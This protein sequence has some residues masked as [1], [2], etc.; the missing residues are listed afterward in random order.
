MKN[1]MIWPNLLPVAALIC[2]GVLVGCAEDVKVSTASKSA[3]SPAPMRFEL[4]SGAPASF[5]ASEPVAT[6][7][8]APSNNDTLVTQQPVSTFSADVDTSSYSF[9]RRLIQQG[10]L[11]PSAIIRPEEMV[12]YFTYDYQ[13]PKSPKEPFQPQVTIVPSPWTSGAQL[14]HIGIKG[15]VPPKANNRAP[16]NLV[17]LI[18]TSGSMTP[19]DRLPMLQKAFR[20][21]VKHLTDQDK[22]AIVTYASGSD[23]AL[24][25][26]SDKEDILEAI[27]D[28]S[29][30]GF[31]A[32]S[33]GLKTAYQLAEEN[34]DKG[35][36]NRV[37]LATD[38]DFNFGISDPNEL[39]QLIAKKRQSGIYLSV[40]GVGQDNYND[41]VMQALAQ[42]GN[43]I[44][45]YLDNLDEARRVLIEQSSSTFQPIANDVK[46]QV[47]FNPARVQSYRLVGYE[48]RMLAEKDFANDKVDAGDIGA[49]HS[50]T[51][52]YEVVE[53]GV[54][55]GV[56]GKR[57][58][59]ANRGQTAQ[60]AAVGDFGFLQ[61]RAKVP[62]AKTSQLFTRH[63][64]AEDQLDRLEQAKPDVRFAI[65]VAGF[66][67]KL[68]GRPI[69]DDI[70]FADIADQAEAARGT[71]KDGRRAEFIR[72][73]RLA[74]DLEE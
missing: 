44:A 5:Y 18:D 4:H 68:G 74:S 49:G 43:G 10:Q 32:G 60:A 73:A 42:K 30:G 17:F 39:E 2:T 14:I 47:E 6:F 46:F 51:A 36:N 56:V 24:K 35:A 19:E 65:A 22:V 59:A 3:A 34:F 40:L 50:V 53:V 54:T 69:G 1:Q 12:N 15:Y 48:T 25:P 27:D 70:T 71:D 11:P 7:P 31:T 16:L 41:A 45:A 64:T 13:P 29:A 66:A 52:I 61:I 26:T 8:I 20:S 33:E 28:L 23:V 58:Y 9:A 55:P 38:G 57:H 72:L 21:L 67:Q 37:I 63:I 62:G